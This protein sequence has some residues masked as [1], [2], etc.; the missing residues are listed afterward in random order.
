MV[1]GSYALDN[2]HF[3]LGPILINLASIGIL[4]NQFLPETSIE[5]LVKKIRGFKN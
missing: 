5:V 4:L 1:Y 2:I 3:R